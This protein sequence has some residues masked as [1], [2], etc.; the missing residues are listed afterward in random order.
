MGGDGDDRGDDIVVAADGSV[1]S[2]G[3]YQGAADFDPQVGT[4]VLASIGSSNTY[5]SK[6]DSSGNFVWARDVGQNTGRYDAHDIDVTPD[7]SIYCTG[8]FFGTSDFDPGTSNYSFTCSG[9]DNDAFISKLLPISAPT[10]IELS[11]NS[12]AEDQTIG[13]VVGSFSSTDPD[14]GE[15]FTYALVSGIGSDENASFAINSSGQLLTAATFDFETKASYNIRVRTTDYSGMSYEKAFT[16]AVTDVNEQPTNIALSNTYV[17]EN[18]PSGTTVGVFSTTDP[19][20]SAT[21]T[22]TLVGGEG[23]TDNASFTIT[24]ATLQTAASFNFEAKQSYSIRVRSTDQGGLSTERVFTIGALDITEVS[25]AIVV[26]SESL[27]VPEG[28]TAQFTVT[29][30]VRPE[31]NRTVL[32]TKSTG[33]DPDLTADVASLL[34]T[35]DNWN[36]PQTV[37]IAAA[38]DLDA[39]SGTTVFVLSSTGVVNRTVTATE[40][41]ETQEVLDW[42][43]TIGLYAPTISTMFLRNTNDTGFADVTFAY[44]PGNTGWKPIAGDWNNDRTGTIGLFDPITS[45]FHLRN[46]NDTGSVDLAFAYGPGNSAGWLPIVG[47]WDGN[48]SDTIG[49]FDPSASR[50]YLRNSNTSGYAELTFDYGPGNNAGWLPIAGD[51]DASGADSVGLFDPVTS[52]FYLRNNNTTGYADLTFSYGPGNNA[53]WKPIAGDWDGDHVDTVGLFEPTASGFYLRNSNTSGFADVTFAYGPGNNAGWQPIVSDWNGPQ[54]V[55]Y[56][57]TVASSAATA[58]MA[59]LTD[60]ELQPVVAEAFARLS[61][62]GVSAA[63]VQSLQQTPFEIV[64]LPDAQVTSTDDGTVY[65]DRDAAGR[66]WS[67]DPTVAKDLDLNELT[68]THVRTAGDVGESTR[69]DLLATVMDELEHLL[70]AENLTEPI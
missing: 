1:Y 21:F 56:P 53:G 12:I 48:G 51:W 31:A 68:A 23:S 24:G 34:F 58:A 57:A 22:Y 37:T 60:A 39:I 11:S 45:Q 13:K 70:D 38:Q 5:V 32:I 61:A 35:P 25:Q 64:D 2:S 54:P 17:A 69:V 28:G 18:R 19:D 33:G 9:I 8:S 4:F 26:S 49:L 36:Q 52:T 47:D 67:L 20:T 40:Q 62:A 16:I 6:L 44:G 30:A 63:A 65:L 42:Q 15:A 7:G 59:P 27:T 55:L 50:F 29:L 43:D 66:G 14:S 41:E 3:R 10:D 46:S